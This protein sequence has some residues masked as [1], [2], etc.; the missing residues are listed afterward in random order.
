MRFHA[1]D[2]GLK[3]ARMPDVVGVHG[4]DIDALRR[5]DAGVTR[6]ANTGVLLLEE[7]DASVCR[8]PS[9]NHGHR[10]VGGSVIDHDYFNGAVRLV[11][12]GSERLLDKVS[13]IVGRYDDRYEVHDRR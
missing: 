11:A 8:R 5:L 10:V 1:G 7:P 12:H 2:L 13:G 9:A 6:G 3:L 4:R